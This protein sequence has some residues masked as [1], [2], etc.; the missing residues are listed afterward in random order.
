MAERFARRSGGSVH[1][2][3]S[4][5]QMEAAECGAVALAIILAYHGRW[6]PVEQLR[7]DCGVSRDGS[8]ANNMLAAA[9]RLG[10]DAEGYKKEPETLH[11]VPM[12][13][14]IHWHFN[15]FVVLEGLKRGRAYINDPA[16]GRR[17]VDM[18]EFD[19][20][21]TGVVLAMTPTSEFKKGGRK[22]DVLR[23][24][25]REL[26]RSRP[27]VALLVALSVAIVVPG[28]L[29]PAFSKIFV[30]NILVEHAEDWLIPLLIGM[31]VA[32]VGRAV[33]TAL[34]Q[35]LLLRLETKHTVGMISRFLW[36]LLSLPMEF[37]AQRHAGDIASRVAANEE[38]ARLLAGGLAVNAL[39]LI[40]LIFFAAAMALYDLQ[41]ALIAIGLSLMNVIALRLVARRREDLNRAL[42]VERGK[43]NVSTVGIVRTIEFVEGGWS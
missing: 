16:G 5:L 8:K 36:H 39:S 28:I 11:E 34:Q 19:T 23:I 3:P 4:I 17:I 42:A 13:C 32:A 37:F 18:A 38:I 15:H 6:I 40:S 12:P 1:P 9:R 21:F 26:R 33:I 7:V 41:L 10:F 29:I 24:L 20:A 25:G 27:A 14:I 43:L 35:S 2:T 22:P 30:D 31:A